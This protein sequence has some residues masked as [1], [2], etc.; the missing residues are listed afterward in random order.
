MTG[1]PAI[2]RVRDGVFFTRS[3]ALPRGRHTL[4]REQVGAA[5]RERV[6]CAATEL[7]AAR[8]YAGFKPSDIARHAGVSLASFYNSFAN[9]D[10]CLF[11]GYDRFIQ[12]VLTMLTTRQPQTNDRA[13]IVA[14]LLCAYL[15]ALANDLVVARAYQVE[16]DALG[17]QARDRRRNALQLI[18]D[19]LHRIV[20]S[21]SPGGIP[22][23]LT[24]S[25]YLGVVYAT[26]QL[27]SDALD[28]QQFPDFSGLAADLQPWIQDLFRDG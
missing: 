27:A 3:P 20:E 5:Q 26:R 9:K 2:E 17:A 12:V 24:P 13:R 16:I 15:D 10:A 25:A 22:E 14:A 28:C 4:S 21:Q 18:A 8:G 11:A 7:L 1:S 23:R 19:A 6:L